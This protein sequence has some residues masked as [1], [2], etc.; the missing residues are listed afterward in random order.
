MTIEKTPHVPVMAEEIIDY[1]N[2]SSEGIYVD[3]TLGMGGHTAAVLQKGGK[4]IKVVAL[5]QDR[6]SLKTAK[7]FLADY[8]IIPS[9]WKIVSKGPVTQRALQKAGYE[10]E[11]LSHA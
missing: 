11:V 4:K 7:N 2:V 1:L 5:D 10:S 8:G 9:H 6:E 3:A